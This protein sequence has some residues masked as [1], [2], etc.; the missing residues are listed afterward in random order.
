MEAPQQR[1]RRPATTY[2]KSV[3]KRYSDFGVGDAFSSATSSREDEQRTGAT[4]TIRSSTILVTTAAT[5]V[6]EQKNREKNETIKSPA[7]TNG[8]EANFL[9]KPLEKRPQMTLKGNNKRSGPVSA[10]TSPQKYLKVFDFDSSDDGIVQP[11][12]TTSNPKG[13]DEFDVPSSDEES[14]AVKKTLLR[15]S[16]KALGA[17]ASMRRFAKEV[18]PGMPGLPTRD[19]KLLRNN[20]QPKE[21]GKQTSTKSVTTASKI[22]KFPSLSKVSKTS[23]APKPSKTTPP[24]S[25][26][27]VTNSSMSLTNFGINELVSQR[28]RVTS[29]QS[30]LPEVD[31]GVL[32]ERHPE[33]KARS[34]QIGLR[35]GSS[36]ELAKPSKLA[37]AKHAR[38][39]V[40]VPLPITCNEPPHPPSPPSLQLSPQATRRDSIPYSPGIFSHV[41]ELSKKDKKQNMEPKRPQRIRGN[42]PRIS[43]IFQNGVEESAPR[44]RR[45]IDRLGT[46]ASQSDLMESLS[47]NNDES[48]EEYSQ[49]QSR[50]IPD[51]QIVDTATEGQSQES[52]TEPL[53]KLVYSNGRVGPKITYA[54]QRSFRMEELDENALFNTPLIMAHQQSNTGLD[55]DEEL[56]DDTGSKMMKTIHE[57]REAG[58][59]NRFLDD[60][61]E[62]FGD[63][64]GGAPLSRQRSG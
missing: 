55:E 31:R 48:E 11:R 23:K 32:G 56:E 1:R 14:L 27:A 58:T 59:N 44:R 52:T 63:I 40:Y 24:E 26:Q 54:R 38:R 29:S 7:L 43:E 61:E 49:S 25:E 12:K 16:S 22:V 3:K 8:G 20:L 2:G 36:N 15:P 6:K 41:D 53:V 45:L 50:N 57:L 28:S 42:V 19:N 62:L 10:A 34:N 46:G 13:N 21:Q 47:S 18:K 17:S 30:G 5:T 35:L 64:E 33:Q 51:P 37:A 4:K 9:T 39:V 60:I